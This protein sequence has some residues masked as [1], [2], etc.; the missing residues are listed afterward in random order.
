MWTDEK[1]KQPGFYWMRGAG[2]EEHVI[3]MV[4]GDEGLE[5]HEHGGFGWDHSFQLDQITAAIEWAECQEP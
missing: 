2:H 4:D 3:K 1:P 5:L